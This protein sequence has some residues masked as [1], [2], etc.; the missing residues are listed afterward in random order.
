MPSTV[1]AQDML[2]SSDSLYVHHE[3]FVSQFLNSLSTEEFPAIYEVL[4]VVEAG[5]AIKKQIASHS[6]SDDFTLS[7]PMLNT[8]LPMRWKEIPSEHDASHVLYQPISEQLMTNAILPGTSQG[9]F[10]PVGSVITDGVVY[11]PLMVD[12]YPAKTNTFETL[13]RLLHQAKTHDTSGNIRSIPYAVS[14][15]I[16]GDG[17]AGTMMKRTLSSVIH[18]MTAQ[19]KAIRNAGNILMATKNDLDQVDTVAGLQMTMM[20]WAPNTE[21][22]VNILV[23]RRQKLWK[24]FEA[25]GGAKVQQDHYRLCNRFGRNE[26]L[27]TINFITSGRNMLRAQTDKMTNSMN[28]MSNTSSGML[29]EFLINLLD[30]SGGGGGDMWKGRAM[31]FIAAL[32]RV[33]VY[34]RDNGFIQLS[35]KVFTQYMELEALEELVFCHNDKYGIDFERVAEQLQGYLVSLP[36]YSSNPKKLKKQETKTREQHGYITMQLT[37]AINDLTFNYGHIFGVEH[38][39]DIDIFDVV[40]NRRILTVPLPALERSP[41]SLKMLGKLIIG[42]IKQMMAGSL[43][44][45][46]EGL[47]RAIID[48]R[49][50]NATTSF[51]LFLDEWGYI[52]IVGASVLPAQARSLNFSI[53]FGAQTFEDIERGSKE[54]AAATWGNTTVKAIGRTTSGAESTTYKLVDGFAGEEWQGKVNSIN[55]YQG[56]VFNRSV[57]QTE[58]QFAKEK[59]VTIEQIAGQHNG[60]FTLLISTKGEGGKTSDVKIVSMLAFYVA[61]AQPKYLRLNDLCPIFNIQK[62]EIYDPTLKIEDFIHEIEEKHTLLTDN[63]SSANVTA[64]GDFE[65]CRKLNNTLYENNN[66]VKD[67]TQD[68]VHQIL[69]A[70]RLESITPEGMAPG[71]RTVM[72]SSTAK[73]EISKEQKHRESIV[74]AQ[75][76]ANIKDQIIEKRKQFQ[77]FGKD[78]DIS[79]KVQAGAYNNADLDAEFNIYGER[80]SEPEQAQQESDVEAVTRALITPMNLDS[81]YDE[82]KEILTGYDLTVAPI[83]EYQLVQMPRHVKPEDQ[84]Q[85]IAENKASLDQAISHSTQNEMEFV[86]QQYAAKFEKALM[87][88]PFSHECVTFEKLLVILGSKG[89]SASLRS[90]ITIKKKDD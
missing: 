15:C 70:R 46:M 55:M 32:T 34:L 63:N 35:P 36:G 31:A 73:G 79:P 47:R 86:E 19:N 16:T 83:T 30:D 85:Y 67:F 1:N 44:N 4:N 59:R 89:S 11:A 81:Y 61:G 41:D 62:S 33:L 39:G 48:A 22:G 6:T 65:I 50:T 2:K 7:V 25:W 52:V 51:K 64:L 87:K 23:G 21:D 78:S 5:L 13:F 12:I 76:E 37:K 18:F 57:P 66:T 14:Y 75:K 82:L 90:G 29:I 27:L 43:G 17:M 28:Q 10:Y 3:S 84:T 80:I 60:E 20:T 77:Y 42:S 88:N 58:V 71:Q 53:T 38:G 68:F 56:L 49:P 72:S 24:S 45:K 8:R 40:L 74:S 54:E 69:E 26:D 9:S